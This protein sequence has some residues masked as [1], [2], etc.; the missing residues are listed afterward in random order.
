VTDGPLLG[1]GD[2][3]SAVGGI[4]FAASPTGLTANFS[5]YMGKMDYWT[6]QNANAG[7]RMVYFSHVAPAHVSLSFASSTKPEGSQCQGQLNGSWCNLPGT[8]PCHEGPECVIGNMRTCSTD[9][10]KV[11]CIA[12][13]KAACVA[14]SKCVAF[15]LL[16]SGPSYELYFQMDKIAEPLPDTDWDY[17]YAFPPKP[18][19]HFSFAAS[20]DLQ[21]A[22]V[23]AT[24]NVSSGNA[25]ETLVVGSSAI[26]HPKKNLLV[27]TLRASQDAILTL[28]LNTPNQYGLPTQAGSNTGEGGSSIWMARSNNKWVH[29][30]A[31]LGECDPLAL[32]AAAT[33][34]FAIDAS[35][36]IGPLRNTTTDSNGKPVVDTTMCMW[37]GTGEWAPSVASRRVSSKCSQ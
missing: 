1:N 37:L 34:S 18:T 10:S 32:M 15:G 21:N 36:N 3:G 16:H 12:Q 7:P 11:Q 28:S 2:L 30:D 26:V 8:I 20:Q 23:N 25:K 29:N 31:V 5:Y 6:Q 4:E 24:L 27:V 17:F 22:E 9:S 35:G 33:R 13:A 19:P 14:N